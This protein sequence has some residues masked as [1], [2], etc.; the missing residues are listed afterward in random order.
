MQPGNAVRKTAPAPQINPNVAKAGGLQSR[1]VKGEAVVFLLQTLDNKGSGALRLVPL[2]G[3]FPDL[4]GV[5]L[6]KTEG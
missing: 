5:A 2:V 1:G 6:A 3:G 4:S